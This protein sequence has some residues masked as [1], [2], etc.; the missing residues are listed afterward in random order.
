ML[1]TFADD[2]IR[3]SRRINVRE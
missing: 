1:E 3:A 2:L